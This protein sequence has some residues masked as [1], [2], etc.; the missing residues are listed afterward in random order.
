MASK[1]DMNEKAASTA[2]DSVAPKASS[3]HESTGRILRVNPFATPYASHPASTTG[4]SIALQQPPQYQYFRSR[5]IKKGEV[6]HPWLD[7]TDPREK[8]VTIIPV[9]GIII[10]LAI[11]GLLVWD[12]LRS[13]VNHEYCLV[14][15]DDFSTGLNSKIWTKEVELGGFG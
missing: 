12:G 6:E 14:L 11:A 5:R 4:S 1:P 7:K 9:I 8:W 10:G 3:E 2:I 13:V 15:N